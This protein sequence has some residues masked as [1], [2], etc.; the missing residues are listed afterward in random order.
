MTDIHSP[1]IYETGCGIAWSD[2]YFSHLPT[3]HHALCTPYSEVIDLLKRVRTQHRFKFNGF[4][5]MSA[6][7]IADL[8]GLDIKQACRA[9]S[10]DFGEPVHWQDSQ[11]AYERFEHVIQQAGLHVIQGGRFAHVMS[12]VNKS[13]AILWLM[14]QYRLSE[15]EIDWQM[16]GLGDS[17][18]DRQLLETVDIAYLVRNL[19]L[20]K[21]QAQM[22][23]LKGLISTT[24]CG[25]AG[26][27]EAISGL[28]KGT[29]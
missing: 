17:P 12:P 26:W 8:T 23:H 29:R 16:V 27:N 15:P 6:S 7:E 1:V 13:S 20:Q 24:Q 25:A 21:E 14:Q 9:K 10:R 4:N 18:N 19:H 5:D 22:M 3:N 11:Q 28:L 2:G